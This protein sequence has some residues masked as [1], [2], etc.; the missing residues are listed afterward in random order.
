M[1]K[2][3]LK[4]HNPK[5]KNPKNLKKSRINKTH[6]HKNIVKHHQHKKTTKVVARKVSKNRLTLKSLLAL[7]SLYTSLTKQNRSSVK[8]LRRS[9]L[10]KLRLSKAYNIQKALSYI[11]LGLF[12]SHLKSE[13]H[14]YVQKRRQ[15][16]SPKVR[17]RR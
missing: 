4:K 12:S 17:R 7:K 16:L 2:I 14:Q 1:F 15:Y 10:N 3:L 6:Q 8:K 5:K 9:I 13:I 11:K